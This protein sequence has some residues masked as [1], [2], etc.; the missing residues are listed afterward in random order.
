MSFY[1]PSIVSLWLLIL[2]GAN[3][4]T[5]WAQLPTPFRTIVKNEQQQPI[6]GAAVQATREDGWIAK[7]VTNASGDATLNLL[8]GKFR[9]D[10]SAPGF[11]RTQLTNVAVPPGGVRI[12]TLVK[13]STVQV[14]TVQVTVRDDA[15]QLV[16]NAEVVVTGGSTQARARTDAHGVATFSLPN[17]AYE[18]IATA[19]GYART[20]GTR[21][22]VP[23]RAS[24]TIVFAAA[25]VPFV[26]TVVDGESK[27]VAGA[28]VRMT[29]AANEALSGTTGS[30]GRAQFSVSRG[31]AKSV[32]ITKAGY[33]A[34]NVSGVQIGAQGGAVQVVLKA[35]EIAYTL[36]VHDESGKPV[37][38]ARALVTSVNGMFVFQGTADASG[39]I[40]L[41]QPSGGYTAAI[42]AAGFRP[43]NFGPFGIAELGSRGSTVTLSVV[44]TPSTP[45]SQTAARPTTT[46][47]TA[48]ATGAKGPS[49]LEVTFV[50]FSRLHV[51]FRDNSTDEKGFNIEVKKGSDAWTQWGFMGVNVTS[52]D[53]SFDRFA[54]YAPDTTYSF[55][56][57]AVGK[58]DYSNVVSVTTPSCAVTPALAAPKL[59]G[60]S[61]VANGATVSG[62]R[63]GLWWYWA[64]IEKSAQFEVQVATDPGFTSVTKA[65]VTS[66]IKA[67]VEVSRS[68]TYYW[69]A[70]VKNTCGSS[71]WSA[72]WSFRT[73]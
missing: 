27:P 40:T 16:A 59:G 19:P 7:G 65:F 20:A 41:R 56:V 52:M 5:A 28:S 36:T 68:T 33:L 12:V 67:D 60:G 53:H 11:T 13:E 4:Q 64:D 48:T 61:S 30:D 58:S 3:L 73:S 2:L 34:G 31:A 51:S 46:P 63:A 24:A 8:P 49:N 1:S 57:Y 66:E 6:S 39:V 23:G 38:G 47:T 15:G 62:S 43:Q 70:R 10:I 42:N 18:V 50:P 35:A 14:S 45:P 54:P 21:V 69:R 37:P 22:E 26:V 29:T 17:G 44:P 9:V 55:R 32:D 71:P 72:A 25:P